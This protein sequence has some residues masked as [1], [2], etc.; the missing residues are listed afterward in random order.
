MIHLHWFYCMKLQIVLW[1]TLQSST[2]KEYL[3]FTKRFFFQFCLEK[4]C[5]EI[6]FHFSSTRSSTSVPDRSKV[7]SPTEKATGATKKIPK[8]TTTF[9]PYSAGVRK[10]GL[11]SNMKD[12]FPASSAPVKYKTK[13]MKA[14]TPTQQQPLKR[15][16]SRSSSGSKKHRDHPLETSS[17]GSGQYEGLGLYVKSTKI[18]LSSTTSSSRGSSPKL[19]IDPMKQGLL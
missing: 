3:F 7:A 17:S 4:K 12:G 14:T 8:R 15:S 2:L 11:A 18:S 10:T 1:K 9:D 6:Y 5:Y 16:S 19:A 13:A